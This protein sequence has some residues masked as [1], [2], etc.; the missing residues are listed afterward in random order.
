MNKNLSVHIRNII[1][2]ILAIWYYCIICS[3]STTSA[4]ES[5]AES[6]M[7]V[8]AVQKVYDVVKTEDAVEKDSWLSG[9]MFHAIVRKAAH[10]YNF[11]IFAFLC[12]ILFS[13]YSD[14]KSL[15]TALTLAMGFCGAVLDETTQAFVPGRSPE[16]T[17]V[18]VD[19]TGT[20]L[21]C[22]FF[23]LLYRKI[24]SDLKRG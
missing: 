2:W 3:F 16:I 7:I 24:V 1:L 8:N 14:K 12:Q 23:V 21:G 19:F 10:V 11:F 5:K 4:T 22:V 18:F 20:V 17:D 15:V 6:Q 9:K 13:V